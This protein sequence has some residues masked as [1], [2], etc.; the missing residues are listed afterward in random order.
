MVGFLY[1]GVLECRTYSLPHI[2]ARKSLTSLSLYNKTNWNKQIK[3]K[4]KSQTLFW[5]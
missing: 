2:E 5:D 3:T 4:K 1:V